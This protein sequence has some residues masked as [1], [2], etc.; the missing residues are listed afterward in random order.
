MGMRV[1]LVGESNLVLQ[2]SPA[3]QQDLAWGWGVQQRLSV[4]HM[5]SLR[6]MLCSSLIRWNRSN[7][8][9]IIIKCSLQ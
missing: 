5:A 8:A 6:V 1:N 4:T 3:R 7:A 9:V 2:A